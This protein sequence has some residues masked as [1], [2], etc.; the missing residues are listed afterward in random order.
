MSL[1]SI[2]LLPECKIRKPPLESRQ[3]PD[4]KITVRNM[5]RIPRIWFSFTTFIVAT[6]CNGFLSVNLEP[7]VRP[8][9]DWRSSK[10]NGLHCTM[11]SSNFIPWQVLRRF[12][13]SP[14]YVGVI[15][16]LKDGANSIASPVWGYLCDKSRLS[17]H[18]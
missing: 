10:L 1:L 11:S 7:Q 3:R 13:L 18:N 6:A 12:E 14:F 17:G 2:P 9:V 16:G 8:M 4:K 15:F 5:L